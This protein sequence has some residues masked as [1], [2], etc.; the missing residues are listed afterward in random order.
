MEYH[1]K[2]A[3]LGWL[4][5]TAPVELHWNL[6][7]SNAADKAAAEGRIQ[8]LAYL[9]ETACPERD[10]LGNLPGALG[11]RQ[12][13]AAA[14]AGQIG[15]LAWLR[16]HVST[17]AWTPSVCKMAIQADRMDALHWLCCICD[18]PCE[19]DAETWRY[20]ASQ[21][22]LNV[23]K[24]LRSTQPPCPLNTL[25]CAAAVEHPDCLKWLR[26]QDPPCPWEMDATEQA[27][28][29]GN[30]SLMQW[31]RAQ[32]DPCPFDWCCMDYAAERGDLDMMRWLY[33]HNP[34]GL[35]FVRG[36]R[37][38]A[39]A[40]GQLRAVQWLRQCSPPC[41]WGHDSLV[42]AARKGS[43]ND[44]LMRWMLSQED[45]CPWQPQVLHKYAAAGN[46]TMLQWLHQ[47]GHH[48]DLAAA[49]FAAQA[50]RLAALGWL[51]SMKDDLLRRHRE[52]KAAGPARFSWRGT[53]PVPSLMLWADH[54]PVCSPSHLSK[55][56]Q[57]ARATYCTL[58]GLIRWR[59]N[60]QMQ[61]SRSSSIGSSRIVNKPSLHALQNCTGSGQELLSL[62]GQLPN[63]LVIR[64]AV[65]ADLQHD[66]PVI[67]TADPEKF[68]QLPV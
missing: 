31:M 42:V 10:C 63:D 12:C 21:G 66:Q 14:E 65:A 55:K 44:E 38:S 1:E 16:D 17:R 23:L 27:V 36:S 19:S 59:R 50:G 68:S 7:L 47:A 30:L 46:L 24:L 45:P 43:S 49:I 40:H 8:V 26:Q 67:G 35:T 39:A 18:P 54:L 15:V 60:Q 9:A 34:C 20:A 28:K 52:A 5:E 62:L 33:A 4:L 64:I 37:S 29:A 57:L 13:M 2:K 48:P 25:V 51:L 56:L 22:K 53:L 41:L 11:T 6:Q 32:D 61:S 58:H 3:C